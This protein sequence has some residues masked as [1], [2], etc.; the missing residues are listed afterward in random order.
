MTTSRVMAKALVF[1]GAG[2]FL[3]VRRHPAS[4][5]RPSQWDLP[6]GKVEEG[7]AHHDAAAREIQEETGITLD[8]AQLQLV[9]AYTSMSEQRNAIRLLY[10]ARTTADTV[11]LSHEHDTYQWV[12]P[13][14]AVDIY[15]YPA[16]K[17]AISYLRDN[18]VLD[19]LAA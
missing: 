7:E 18:H 11:T 6:G 14:E 1:N 15:D 16:H 3:I 8:P 13:D 19:N 9:Y 5:N 12:T 2:K 4:R 10:M 17:Q